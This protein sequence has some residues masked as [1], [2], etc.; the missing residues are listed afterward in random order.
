MCKGVEARK[1]TDHENLTLC[2]LHF[3]KPYSLHFIITVYVL[4]AY[5]CVCMCMGVWVLIYVYVC[6]VCPRTCVYGNADAVCWFVYINVH[7]CVCVYK[8][9]CVY[10]CVCACEGTFV[11]QFRSGVRERVSGVAW[12]HPLCT[13]ITFIRLTH[14]CTWV[15]R[16][17]TE[18][19]QCCSLWLM[20]RRQI[21]EAH[22]IQWGGQASI[23][24]TNTPEPVMA[25]ASRW[26]WQ[27]GK[28][29]I[30]ASLLKWC[31]RGGFR[32]TWVLVFWAPEEWN[33][34]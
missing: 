23:L 20:G 27:Q 4:C 3:Y 22:E 21:L 19:K 29:P 8:Y 5:A 13:V 10:I 14:I 18:E 16:R 31:V 15:K 25:E 11:P 30:L 7:M 28:V 12:L 6:E 32:V 34:H 2:S 33:C 26:Q 1:E 9:A 17:A 24:Y